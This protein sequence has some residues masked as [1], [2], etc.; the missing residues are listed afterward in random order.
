[1]RKECYKIWESTA[2]KEAAKI[3]YD[4]KDCHVVDHLGLGV[5]IRKGDLSFWCDG[6]E[7]EVFDHKADDIKQIIKLTD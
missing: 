4:I 1:M 3:G 7:L 6:F 2:I 5:F